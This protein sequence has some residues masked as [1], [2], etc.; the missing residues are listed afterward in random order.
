VS[1][2]SGFTSVGATDGAAALP[3]PSPPKPAERRALHRLLRIAHLARHAGVCRLRLLA[4]LPP[5]EDQHADDND[6]PDLQEQAKDRSKPGE[7][8]EEAM[9]HQH[10]DQAGAE[11]TTSETAEQTA[12]EHSTGRLRHRWAGASRIHAGRARLRHRAVHRRCRIWSCG[13]RRRR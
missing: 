9:A 2:S 5:A 6:E 3:P 4:A 11:Q 10:A 7:A 1:K 12:A 13:S 8:A